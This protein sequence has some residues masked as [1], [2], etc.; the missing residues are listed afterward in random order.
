MNADIRDTLAVRYL[1]A[2]EFWKMLMAV[3]AE[4]GG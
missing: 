4:T 3:P 1:G 2:P